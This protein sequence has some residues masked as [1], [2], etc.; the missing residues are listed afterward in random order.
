[1]T[2]PANT[3]NAQSLWGE[4]PIPGERPVLWQIGPLHLWCKSLD[5]ELWIASRRADGVGETS[6]D[7]DRENGLDWSRWALD[8]PYKTLH[9][10]PVFPDR[11]VVI[12]PD[13]PFRLR[14][15][16]GRATVYVPVPLWIKIDLSD[17]NGQTTLIEIPTV[18]FSDTWCGSYTHGELC[19]W[20]SS[21]AEGTLNIEEL[22]FHV[23]ACP[24]RMKNGSNSD[25]LIDK[26]CLYVENLSLFEREGKLMADETKIDFQEGSEVSQVEVTGKEPIPN[27]KLIAAPR[28]IQRRS[29]SARSLLT[30]LPTFGILS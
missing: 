4:Y 14:K 25:L 9:L 8:H 22:P 30:N 13:V 10:V 1:M 7:P 27:A 28:N 16:G 15:D 11:P 12:K 19:Y 6:I 5:N 20:I 2:P 21:Y 24:I 3:A 29:F 17:G 23:A 26:L 18:C